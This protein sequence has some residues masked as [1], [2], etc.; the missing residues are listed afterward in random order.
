MQFELVE[1]YLA[2]LISACWG[3]LPF[4]EVLRSQGLQMNQEIGS[5]GHSFLKFYHPLCHHSCFCGSH[6]GK[7]ECTGKFG[8]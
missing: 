8:H 4:F 2:L 7:C 1:I 3:Y 5:L 6:H